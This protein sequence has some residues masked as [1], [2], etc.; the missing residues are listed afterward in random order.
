LDS[1][2]PQAVSEILKRINKIEKTL[3]IPIS[4]SGSTTETQA[5]AQTLKGLFEDHWQKHFLWLTDREAFSKLESS[6]FKDCSRFTIQV[7]GA[8]DIGGRFTCPHTLIFLLPLFLVM[9]RDLEKVKKIFL[10]YTSLREEIIKKAYQ[11]AFN[12][13]DAE[14]GYFYVEVEDKFIRGIRTWVTQLFQE[15]LGSKKKNFF[16]KTLVGSKEEKEEGFS[17]VD[18]DIET[19]NP[20]V[21]LMGLMHYL[22]IF[23]ACFAYFNNIN[24]VN[25][26]YVEKYK[27]TMRELGEEDL[28]IPPK[29]DLEGLADQ[30]RKKLK[31]SIE[32][33][34]IVLYFHPEGGFA[35]RLKEY[36]REQ[37]PGRRVLVFLGSDWNHHS[38]Q[39]AFLDENTLY[40]VL[41]LTHYLEDISSINR[42]ALSRNIKTLRLISLATHKTLQ[43]KSLYF[44]L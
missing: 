20:S 44:C 5:L 3:V 6:G 4:K 24:F 37:F 35:Q 36:L 33:L 25:Q 31:P 40:V 22:Q 28:S 42:E 17:L 8:S 2:D 38:Y 27:Q 15:S 12:Y 10:E 30:I 34:E 7:N 9:D 18:F 19:D 26:P 1:L 29:I 21:Y 16:V 41:T 23:V 32:F 39:A 11:L 13:R 14:R 43:D